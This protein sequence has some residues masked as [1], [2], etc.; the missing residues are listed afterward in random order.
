MNPK[1]SAPGIRGVRGGI[2]SIGQLAQLLKPA[3]APASLVQPPLA[4]GATNKSTV[5]A[6][7][8]T[9]VTLIGGLATWTFPYPFNAAP[10]ITITPV[11]AP[12][13]GTSQVYIVAGFP[14]AKQVQI[15]ST[16]NTDARVI[17]LTASGNPN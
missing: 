16:S 12:V 8:Q 9:T 3:F 13:A 4:S 1:R 14:T 5:P 17:H 2:T 10:V 11:G 7:Q 15:K 6:G